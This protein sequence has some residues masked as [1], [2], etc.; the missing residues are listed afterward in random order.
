MLGGLSIW[1]IKHVS[2]WDG[3]YVWWDVNV[4]IVCCFFSISTREVLGK[5]GREYRGFEPLAGLQVSK[6]QNVSS[7]LTHKDSIMLG[8]SVIER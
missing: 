4:E 1:V 2:L 8:T 5:I 6:K 7:P 3:Y